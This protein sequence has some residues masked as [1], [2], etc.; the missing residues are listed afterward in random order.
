MELTERDLLP[1]LVRIALDENKD[2][3]L[4]K[5]AGSS[6]TKKEELAKFKPI[7]LSLFRMAK[8]CVIRWAEWIPDPTRKFGAALQTLRDNQVHLHFEFKYFRPEHAQ[9]FL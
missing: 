7:V 4:M 8:E 9:F 2:K 6:Y 5:Y 3:A 1:V